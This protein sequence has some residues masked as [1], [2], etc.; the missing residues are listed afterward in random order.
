[1]IYLEAQ[2]L[3]RR[4]ICEYSIW[5]SNINIYIV[6]IH[7]SN[8]LVSGS[9]VDELWKWEELKRGIYIG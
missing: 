4:N 1:M 6:N 5:S 9:L 7:M 2:Y 3:L 8:N